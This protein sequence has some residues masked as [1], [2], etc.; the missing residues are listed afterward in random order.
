MVVSGSAPSSGAIFAPF[1]PAA[2]AAGE[3]GVTGGGVVSCG[4]NVW[5]EDNGG[6]TAV[7]TPPGGRTAWRGVVV[8]AGGKAC[9]EDEDGATPP[10]GRTSRRGVFVSAGGNVC[11]ED[12]DEST[13]AASSGATAATEGGVG[14]NVWGE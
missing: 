9:G 11:G 4:G 6:S 14:G 2:A 7:A 1:D 5:V 13:A 3:I 10:G 8:S 12:E